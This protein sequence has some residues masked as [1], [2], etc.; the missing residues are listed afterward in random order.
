MLSCPI[1]YELT[2]PSLFF[3]HPG[4]GSKHPFCRPCLLQLVAK[5]ASSNFITCP[6]C[7]DEIAIDAS[8]TWKERFDLTY[9]EMKIYLK[10]A[11]ILG[12]SGAIIGATGGAAATLVNPNL[13]LE[14]GMF[15]GAVLFSLTGVFSI[16]LTQGFRD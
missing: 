5:A 13:S 11:V 14:Q 8:V 6:C 1:C 10:G 12:I 9:Q 15:Q 7:R 16:I 2:P 4:D 3:S